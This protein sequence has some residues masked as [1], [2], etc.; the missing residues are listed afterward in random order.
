MGSED[1]DSREQ[2]VDF[3]SFA[4]DLQS[5][6]YPVTSERIVEEDGD[7]RLDLVDGTKTV[8]EV[9]EPQGE[10][11]FDSPD[12]VQSAILNMVGSTAVGREGYSDRGTDASDSD[13]SEQSL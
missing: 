11:T 1:A 5:Y 4:D 13:E 3:G 2:G 6:D 9:L 12:D 10:Q 8:R 7:E